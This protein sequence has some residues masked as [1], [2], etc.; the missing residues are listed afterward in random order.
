MTDSA[1]TPASAPGA[2]PPASSHGLSDLSDK[3]FRRRRPLRRS[4]R[5]KR[6]LS[7]VTKLGLRLMRLGTAARLAVTDV[8]ENWGGPRSRLIAEFPGKAPRGGMALALY[9][10][11][12][13]HSGISEM[14]LAQLRAY[15]DLGFRVVFISSSPRLDAADV[16]ALAGSA[17]LILHRRNFAL[18]FGAWS[19]ALAL[20]PD[21]LDGM[22]ELLLVNDS[23]LGPLRPLDTMFARLRAGGDGLFGLTDSVQFAPHVQSYFLLARGAAAIDDVAH[24]LGTQRLSARKQTVI[25]RFEVGLSEHMRN[26]G[27]RVASAFGYDDLEDEVLR[28][29]VDTAALL[30]VLPGGRSLSGGPGW[31]FNLRRHLLDLPLNPVHHFAGVLIRR[32]GF[33]FLKTELVL[34]NPERLPEL[35]NWRALVPG[36]APVSVAM[37]ED[38]LAAHERPR[39]RRPPRP[40]QA[41]AAPS[42]AAST[43]GP[44]PASRP[45]H[46]PLLAAWAPRGPAGDSGDAPTL[47]APTLDATTLTARLPQVPFVL[48]VSHDDYA[49]H[50]G[51]V[52]NVI[53]A[54]QRAFA[55]EGIAYLHIA[56][57][58]PS[59]GL[60]LPAPDATYSVRL[61]G[62]RLGTVRH[63]ALLAVCRTL[64]AQ[65]AVMA[66]LVHHLSG[67]AP[68][69]V[70][71]LIEAAQAPETL[72]WLHDFGTLCETP[73]L[74]RNHVAF[75]GGPPLDSAACLVCAFGETRPSHLARIGAFFDTV[76]PVVVAPSQA[77]LDFWRARVTWPAAD[78]IVLPPARLVPLPAVPAIRRPR[79]RLRVAHLGARA[80]HKGWPDF[81]ALAEGLAGE[82]RYDFLQFGVD[83][84]LPPSAAVR[85]VPVE[86]SPE[87]PMAMVDALLDEDVEVVVNWSQCHETFSFTTHEALAA[88]AF[89]V[90]P[91]GAG[92]IPEV[93]ARIAPAQGLILPDAAALHELFA[94]DGLRTALAQAQRT[95]HMLTFGG[96]SAEWLLGRRADD[97]QRALYGHG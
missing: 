79:Q 11:Y 49:A 88:G 60:V 70:R 62:V 5:L 40:R 76:R 53:A 31:Q 37:I 7:P 42:V 32:C 83:A 20:H 85:R 97:R 27:H 52:Q 14:V 2:A 43:A 78:H 46:D 63:E 75:C 19:D 74:L 28:S 65:K 23:V 6:L 90:A 1:E 44:P 59:S 87:H 17:A 10:H 35:V 38:H 61:D 82:R 84:A 18:D 94:G 54:E 77:A 21:L 41:E 51:G 69:H 34:K 29:E 55:A 26:L 66:G 15:A 47:S 8:R 3:P 24:F 30:A 4:R 67:H 33:P 22:D 12:S 72:V 96:A 93:I 92:N 13:P 16:D 64:G 45:W 58:T 71:D 57:A 81:A 95:R 9:A 39:R 80:S 56:P 48:S 73:V 91:A 68:E 86:V 36:D 25:E 89:V 50:C